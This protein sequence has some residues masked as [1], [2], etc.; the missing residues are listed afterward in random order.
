MAV[1][2]RQA[3]IISLLGSAIVIIAGSAAKGA[4]P[5]ARRLFATGTV[6]VAVAVVADTMP[7]VAKPAAGIA[8]VAIAL[9]EGAGAFRALS[10]IAESDDPLT[11][12]KSPDTAYIGPGSVAG[13]PNLPGASPIPTGPQGQPKPGGVD[14][15]WG[16]TKPIAEAL[17]SASGLRVSST[18]RARKLTDSGNVSD[19]WTGCEVC[20]AVDLPV[21][22][23]AGDVA[24]AKVM[25]A[26]GDP[27]Y[28]GGRWYNKHVN[29]YRI[30][31]G[32]R[33]AGHF[34][35]IHIGVRRL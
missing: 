9:S 3:V 15:S 8:F 22:G 18:K 17:A 21:T 6:Y 33:V 1:P 10:G 16:G 12:A 19:H 23:A 35:H 24:L 2:A 7:R 5:S 31:I 27:S 29:G 11:G 25:Q 28:K 4:L 30:Q 32:W 14:G 13:I 34:D 20:Y 26:L